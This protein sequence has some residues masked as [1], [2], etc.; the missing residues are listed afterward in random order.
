MVERGE[1]NK[2]RAVPV[3]LLVMALGYV[4]YAVKY[5]LGSFRSPGALVSSPC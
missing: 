5:N 3:I 4:A 1:L 2:D